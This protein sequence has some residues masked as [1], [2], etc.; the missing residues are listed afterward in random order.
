VTNLLLAEAL[1]LR[2]TRTMWAL[3][4]ATVAVSALAVASAVIVGADANLDLESARGAREIMNVTANGAI[5]VLVL[6][7]IVS[8]GEFRMG[9][10]TD[11][12]LTTPRR[13]RVV[14]A[15]LVTAAGVGLLFGALAAGV[16]LG[17]AGLSYRLE[18]LTFPLGSSDAWSTLGGSVLYAALFGAIGAATG[19]LVRNQ[20]V[21][22]V[23]W[24]VWIAVVE[25]IATGFAPDIG[26]W[27]PVA[28][29]RALVGETGQ[30]LLSRGAAAIVLASYA[31]VIMG[32]AI[33][34]ERYRDA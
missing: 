5:F 23:G 22:I 27:L 1:K 19:S 33:V 7:V 15:K 20:V 34:T 30:D 24:L 6:G 11:T 13:W 32:M 16:S 10:A 17:V 3:L 8:A 14:A 4:G 28:A 25:H 21:A 2:T 9:T 31:I 26:R 29:G 18:G 12:F